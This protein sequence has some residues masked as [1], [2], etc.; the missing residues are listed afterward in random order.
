MLHVQCAMK[1]RPG[2][3]TEAERPP[4]LSYV[5]KDGIGS[6]REPTEGLQDK[7]DLDGPIW[8]RQF[9]LVLCVCWPSSAWTT[10]VTTFRVGINASR[11]KIK[12]YAHGAL[13]K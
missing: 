1:T 5:E 11:R 9:W 10:L 4:I 8:G 3:L 6:G 12:G 7:V 2:Q 13:A